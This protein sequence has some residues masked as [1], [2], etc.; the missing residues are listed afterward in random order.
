M[1]SSGLASFG[2]FFSSLCRLLKRCWL[3]LSFFRRVFFAVLLL[4]FIVIK[5]ILIF[6]Y[7]SK[8]LFAGL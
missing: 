7:L 5:S 3:F 4:A 2:N 8:S 1:L 6:L